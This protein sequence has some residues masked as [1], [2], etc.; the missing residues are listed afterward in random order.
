M[1]KNNISLT[2][3]KALSHFFCFKLLHCFLLETSLI[4]V[5]LQCRHQTTNG[6]F[7]GN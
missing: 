2:I 7:E 1:T 5:V 4:F 3:A 6:G